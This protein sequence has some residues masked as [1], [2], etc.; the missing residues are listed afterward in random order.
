M[1]GK[2]VFVVED[3]RRVVVLAGSAGWMV[4]SGVSSLDKIKLRCYNFSK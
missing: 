1:V 4:L 2:Q 3:G